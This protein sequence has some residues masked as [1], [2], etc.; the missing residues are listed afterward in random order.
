M[1]TAAARL[2][3]AG[4]WRKL[5][6][7]AVRDP[8]E[9]CDLLA[10]P[11]PIRAAA[12]RSARLFPLV[13]PRGYVARMRPGDSRDPLLLQVLPAMEE[14]LDVPGFSTDPVGDQA[15][16]RA[17]GLL[18]K[19]AGRALLITT[20]VCAIHCRYCFRR[21]FPYEDAPRGLEQWRPAID[22]IAADPSIEE[23]LLSGG[24]PLTLTDDWL[25][26]LVDQ[27]AAI[28]HLRRLRVHTRLPIVIPQRVDSKLLEWMTTGRLQTIVVVHANHPNELDESCSIALRRLVDAG[29]L[30]FN[31]SVLL[32]GIN[33]AADTLAEL[34][35]RLIDL[36]VVPYYLH[37]LDR[38]AGA[39]HFEVPIERGLQ[40]MHELRQ[41]L[42]G[43][44]MPKYVREVP[45][46]AS[47]I[48]LR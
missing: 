33:D 14:T 17:P 22:Q 10:L 12:R 27:L 15:A 24:D 1:E 16:Q 21:H 23:V 43:Y 9:L 31:Q 30:V 25:A 36:R 26:R 34:C 37:Q 46:A 42:P 28:G 38:V 13:A 29:L 2:P 4:N 5:L 18:Q 45:G 8:N 11:E 32:R 40:L 47:K 48:E 3:A 44:A 35:R 41:R 20:G 6:A 7:D 39:A 19:Y